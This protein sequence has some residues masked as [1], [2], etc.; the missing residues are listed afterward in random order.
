MASRRLTIWLAVGFLARK[1]SRFDPHSHVETTKELLV[2]AAMG[3]PR[4]PWPCTPH[5]CT[6]A[7][8]LLYS[9]AW[10]CRGSSLD[11]EVKGV[12]KP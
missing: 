12:G 10:Q 7:G 8:A 2:A 4:S 3:Y 11:I 9:Q 1:R 5:K 6:G